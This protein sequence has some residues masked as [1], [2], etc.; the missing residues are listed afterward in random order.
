MIQRPL[1]VDQLEECF[2]Q[3]KQMRDSQPVVYDDATNSW[4]LVRYQDILQTFTKVT[5]FVPLSM[6]EVEPQ[7]VSSMYPLPY[8]LVHRLLSTVLTP[9]DVSKLAPRIREITQTL[10]ERVRPRGTMDV[11]GNLAAPLSFAV[12]AELLDIPVDQ[13]TRLKGA[14]ALNGE[15]WTGPLSRRAG[16]SA[17]NE[18]YEHIVVMGQEFSALLAE[19]LAKHRSLPQDDLISRLLA[20]PL[21][22][23]V[24]GETEVMACCRWLLTIASEA[25]THL[26]GNAV[27]CLD[28]HPEV[29]EHL[30]QE[31][32]PIY[33]TIE[34]VLRYLPPLWMVFMRAT[35][36]VVLGEQ[37]IP[38]G[39]RIAAWIASA[40]RDARHFL[41]PD[42]F[43]IERI[44]NRHLSFGYGR[45]F[46][47]DA[48]LAR[49]QTEVGLSMLLDQLPDLKV[50]PDQHLEVVDNPA[51]FGVKSLPITFTP[52]P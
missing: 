29:M 38:A 50:L 41:Q 25:T 33:S 9:E 34:E 13:L 22:G 37:S 44:P 42:V 24:I 5:H 49:L 11:I 30:R 1:F 52:T 26:L 12:I 6:E 47:F 7:T 40:N 51:I 14:D 8:S 17:R 21:E 27:L 19:L 31:P 45:S 18:R 43:D 15:Q 32:A 46:R 10:L 4:H 3:L 2:T 35:S 39:A 16:E 28:A 36:P 20:L 48:A 23:T